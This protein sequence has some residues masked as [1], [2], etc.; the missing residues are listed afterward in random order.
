MLKLNND[1]KKNKTI[2]CLATLFM[3]IG[4]YAQVTPTILGDRHA[5]LRLDKQKKYLLLPV[6]EKEENAHIRV[7][8]NNQLEKTF[9]CRL[10]VD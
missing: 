3:A 7:V 9:N 8:R 4:G 2:A 10:A 1:M 6:E 5:M